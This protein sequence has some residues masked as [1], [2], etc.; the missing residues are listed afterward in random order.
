MGNNL[1]NGYTTD[2]ETT[3]VRLSS[4]EN[5]GSMLT[6]QKPT[7]RVDKARNFRLKLGHYAIE[8]DL[9]GGCIQ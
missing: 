4:M 7:E 5:G 2:R 9:E 3:K 1:S 6:F 8:S